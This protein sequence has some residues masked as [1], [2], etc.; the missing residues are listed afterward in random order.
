V[1]KVTVP[2][3]RELETIAALRADASVLY[4]EPNYIAYA[5]DTNP[6]DALY[7]NQWGLAKIN[8]PAAWDI[9]T[10][11]SDVIIAVVDTGIDLQHPDFACPGK[12]TAGYNFSDGNS[13]PDDNNG[14]GSHVAGIAAACTNNSTGVAGLAWG[15]RL[16][17]VKVLNASGSGSYFQVAQGITFAVD[18]GADIV[19]LSLGG[20]DPDTTLANAIQD[21]VDNGVL[22]VVAAGN[23]AQ[24]G[25]LCRNIVNPVVYPAAYNTTLAV[26]ATD[27]GDGWASFSEH[28][29]YVDVA[30]PGVSIYS[31]IITSYGY[32]SGTSMATPYVAGLAALVWSVSP[33]LNL[34]QVRAAI[35]S[36]ADDLQVP[37]G[38]GQPGKDDYTGYGRINAWRALDGLVSLQTTPEEG[39]F[40]I[41]G[42]SGPFPSNQEIQVTTDSSEAISWSAS[43]SPDVAWLDI[44]PPASGTVSAAAPDSFALVVPTRPGSYGV[45]TTTVVVTATTSGGATFGPATSE[46]RIHY[47][48]NFY[49]FRFP[50][51]YKNS[52][53]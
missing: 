28:H 50:I 36:S 49:E 11:N 7:V 29:P 30:A 44:V 32:K 41:D 19:N 5:L 3:G 25:P 31:T 20:L 26:A 37:P 48:P 13:N 10:G 45:Y 23:C 2:P 24:G 52:A 38:Y 1:L 43:I 18:N 51:M 33:G 21:A 8:A 12:L 47:V 16:M 39:N 46:V 34:A 15:A 42:D 6:N 53:P 40:I 4:A 27:S 17:P 9:S 14:H 35:E 22:V